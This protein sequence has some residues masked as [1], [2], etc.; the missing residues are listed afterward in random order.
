[1]LKHVNILLI[2]IGPNS[3]RL[4]L[5]AIRQ[6]R[7][8]P[9]ALKAVVDVE[10]SKDNVISRLRKHN[11]D[12]ASIHQLYLHRLPHQIFKLSS[13]QVAKLDK[14]IHD[15]DINAV[16]IA[17]DP[18]AHKAYALWA[19]SHNLPIL[20][21]KPVTARINTAHD[22][23][24]ARGIYEDYL[25]LLEAYTQS[26][27]SIFSLSVQRRYHVGFNL[28]FDKIREIKEAFDMPVTS[29]Q[30]LHADGQWRMPSEIIEQIYH[31]YN[32]YGKVSHSG[33]HF[34][35]LIARLI[36]ASYQDSNSPKRITS[37]NTYSSFVEPRGLLKQ[38][39]Q[40]DYKKIL[41]NAYE[42]T[43]QLTDKELF[44]AYENFG[45]VD[46]TSILQLMNGDDVI[47]NITLNLL[48]NSFSRRDWIL[49]GEDLYKGNGRVKHEYHNI[50]QGPFQNI[51]IH[52]YQKNDKHDGSSADDFLI[53]GNN[54]FDINIFRNN[55]LT[56]DTEPLQ[57]YTMA[58]LTRSDFDTELN[59]HDQIK[60]KVVYEFLDYLLGKI[61]RSQLSSLFETH[62]LSALIMSLIYQSAASKTTVSHPITLQNN[63]RK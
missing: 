38:L 20:M 15:A 44:K 2:G 25:E 35:D 8:L 7:D 18:L 45:E 62:R 63:F 48:H 54:H 4:Y 22:I 50:Q 58:D 13:D 41:G 3:D 30:S 14:L 43:S 51:Q 61:D 17:T 9:V 23:I 19:L 10:D 28:V 5:P 56:G 46:A 24:E 55:A 39:N 36:E 11:Y 40:N 27:T 47:G 53:G 16:I 57:I 33:Y 26:K 29:V 49:P 1:M 12:T 42:H 34:T 52:S 59:I 6:S 31:P 37:I 32:I 60:H 21:D